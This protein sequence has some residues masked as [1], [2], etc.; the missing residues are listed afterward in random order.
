MNTRRNFLQQ[1]LLATASIM[2]TNS[3][4]GSEGKS[5]I[6]ISLAEWSLHRA[7]QEGRLDN[8]DF[9]AK[10]KKDFGVSVVEYVNGLFGG[11]SMNFK[12]AGKS[13]DYLSQLLKRSKDAGVI[14]HLIMVDEEGPLALPDDKVRLEAVENHKKW[15]DAAKFLGCKTV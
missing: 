3:T 6:E 15:F 11:K 1:S 4:F 5:G 13:K 9:P 14:N 2:L 8:L 7:I 12:E 10:A